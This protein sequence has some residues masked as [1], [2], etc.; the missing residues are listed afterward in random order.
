MSQANPSDYSRDKISALVDGRTQKQLD[1]I[2]LRYSEPGA[3]VGES[4]VIR[5]ALQLY[6]QM[7]H[8]DPENCDPT[9]R[10]GVELDLE[11][12][13]AKEGAA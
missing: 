9:K 6:I 13:S 12:P 4:E 7:Y 1:E 2:R 11:E 8:Q 3:V 5:E 10:G